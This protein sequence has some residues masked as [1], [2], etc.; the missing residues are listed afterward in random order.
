MRGRVAEKRHGGARETL[1]GGD[2]AP[3]RPRGNPRP[4][5]TAIALSPQGPRPVSMAPLHVCIAVARS[6]PLSLPLALPL[7]LARCPLRP[8]LHFFSGAMAAPRFAFPASLFSASRGHMR[9]RASVQEAPAMRPVQVGARSSPRLMLVSDLDSTMVWFFFL[10]LPFL[11][12]FGLLPPSNFVSL[13]SFSS[14]LSQLH[15]PTN[16]RNYGCLQLHMMQGLNL[17]PL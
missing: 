12:R 17:Q 1:G 5:H 13:W 14:F 4:M 8:S 6:P 10:A 3:E 16:I 9:F 7:P 2:Q 15:T 11:L